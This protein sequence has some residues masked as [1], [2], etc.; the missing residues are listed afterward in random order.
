MTVA[1]MISAQREDADTLCARKMLEIA[2]AEMDAAQHDLLTRWAPD[3]A[4]YGRAFERYQTAARTYHA[5]AKVA[6]AYFRT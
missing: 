5:L 1:P 3:Q 6:G 4:H 2:K